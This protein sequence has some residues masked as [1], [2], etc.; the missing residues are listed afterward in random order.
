MDTEQ[1]QGKRVKLLSCVYK[2]K[3]TKE[4]YET[5]LSNIIPL[6]GVNLRQ[7]ARKCSHSSH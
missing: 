7:Y 4:L 3:T 2:H 1:L 5:L 6:I